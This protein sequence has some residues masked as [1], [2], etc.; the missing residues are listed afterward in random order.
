MTL[1]PIGPVKPSYVSL[2][3]IPMLG[4]GGATFSTQFNP[5][6]DD[7]STLPVQAILR[8]ALSLG[9][10]LIDTSPYY[11][12]S[13]IVL[14]RALKAAWA[15]GWSRQG[16]FICTKVGR[17]EI[18]KF[19][20]SV[21]AVRE[22]VNRS[23]V[24]LGVQILDV[25]YC[26]D[27]EFVTKK[28]VL[29]AVAELFKLQEE[30]KIRYIGISGSLPRTALWMKTDCRTPGEIVGGIVRGSQERVEKAFGYR[31]ELLQYDVAK[32]NSHRGSSGILCS[33]RSKSTYRVTSLDGSPS[34]NWAYAMASSY[35]ITKRCCDESLQIRRIPRP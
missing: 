30:G 22:S 7:E 1:Q 12:N 5:S 15:D 31:I 33:R 6:P 20:Y 35:K 11:G 29:D 25:V 8:R 24:R 32:H 4:L 3:T 14:G 23:L 18:D 17:I 26:H 19:D 28:E 21:K 2:N 13:E 27:V 34:V 9:I 10:N 16:M